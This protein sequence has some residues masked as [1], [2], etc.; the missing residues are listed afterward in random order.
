MTATAQNRPAP[1]FHECQEA[2]GIPTSENIC[3]CLEH[4]QRRGG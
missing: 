4:T 3:G 2:C 1:R